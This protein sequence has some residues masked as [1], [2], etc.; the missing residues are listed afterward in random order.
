M[1]ATHFDFSTANA[2]ANT[3]TPGVAGHGL[4]NAGWHYGYYP[5]ADDP[6][7]V[8]T[9]SGMSP[10][11]EYWRGPRGDTT[12]VHDRFQ[13]HPADVLW[14]VV[15]RYTVGAA[16]GEPLPSG[17]VRIVGRF[18]D[19]N[20]GESDVF[21]AI[22]ADGPSGAGG[23]AFP[24]P[25]SAA[26]SPTPPSGIRQVRGTRGVGFDFTTT[27][28]SGA[29]ID[30]GVLA[31]GS[32][33]SD[34]TG[35]VAWLVTGDTAVPTDLVADDYSSLVF[36]VY[37]GSDTRGN[38]F[39]TATDGVFGG[40]DATS[41]DTTPG[42][43]Y[44]HAGLLYLE[45][46]GSGKVTRF[47][48]V[49]IDV[50]TGADFAELPHL[51]LLRHNSDPGSL[52][53]A[54]D[55]RYVQLPVTA[56]RTAANTA[57]QPYYTFDLTSLPESQRTGYGFAVFGRGGYSGGAIAVSEISADA[58]RVSDAGY[59][60][61]KPV[62]MEYDGH[63][64]GLSLNRGTW[65]QTEMEGVSYGGHLVSLNSAAE[66][67]WVFDALGR[68]PGTFIG[69]RQ[70][71]L[72]TNVEPNGGWTWMDGTV[73]SEINGSNVPGV[74][75]NWNDASVGG[76]EPNHADGAGED[77]GCFAPL[78]F[79]GR[80]TW[81]D[82]KNAGYP[83]TSNYRG[84]IEL[85]TPASPGSERNHQLTVSGQAN[86]FGAGQTDPTPTVSVGQGG[87]AAPYIPVFGGE[88]VRLTASGGTV[89]SGAPGAGA[90]VPDGE[91]HP[92]RRC[93]ITG[94]AGVSGY[95]N[96][97]NSAHLVGVFVSDTPLAQTPARLD[98]SADA[99]GEAFTSLSPGLGQVFFIG[100]GLT[101]GGKVQKFEA[102]AGATRL[103]IGFPDAFEGN[104]TYV[105]TGPPN[106]YGDNSGSWSIRLA[107]TPGPTP[108]ILNSRF[109]AS[110]GSFTISGGQPP[111]D[112]I[113]VSAGSLPPGITITSNTVQGRPTAGGTYPVTLRTEDAA[114]VEA[115]KTYPLNVAGAPSGM[116]A[117]WKADTDAQDSIGDN[118]GTSTG[119]NAMATGGG[120]VGSGSF[121]FT[122]TDVITVPDAEV[123]NLVGDFTM[124]MWL[125][126][127]VATGMEETILSKRNTDNSQVSYV[128]YLL[129]DGRLSFASRSLANDWVIT[130]TS[131]VLPADSDWRHL[132][133]TC[134]GT[135]L[136]FYVNGV[137]V[138]TT[139]HP[140]RSA[141]A[142]PL[143]IG[144][145]RVNGVATS[146]FDFSGRID[147]LSLYSRALNGSEISSIV[148]ADSMGKHPGTQ[149]SL[150]DGEL[151]FAGG[152]LLIEG[153]TGPYT[154]TIV[155]GSLPPGLAISSTGLV[156]GKAGNGAYAFTL[157][158]V[159]SLG[160]NSDRS[161]SGTIENP[162]P[163]VPGLLTWWPGENAVGE[164]I[165]GN[166]GSLKNGATYGAG[167]VGRS[168]SFDGVDDFALVPGS[169]ALNLAG[170]M[171]IE[172]WIKHSA[173]SAQEPTIIAKR[174][175]D[176]LNTAYVVFLLADGRLS[177]ASCLSGVWTTVSAPTPLALN[178]WNHVAVTLTGGQICFYV[179]GQLA[180]TLAFT[181][182][183]PTIPEPVTIG[184][185]LTSINTE[186]NP[187][188]EFPG[189][190][191]ELSLY[192]RALGDIEI[193]TIHLAGAGGK[194]RHDVARDYS[195]TTADGPVWSYRWLPS[196]ALNATYNP[197]DANANL[198]G[199]NATDGNG[200]D[201]WS[202]PSYISH[203]STDA[204]VG[205][206]S[207]G[208]QYDWNARQFGMGP[209]GSSEFAVV[210]WKAPQ[211]GLYAVSG[212]F[213]GCDT[214]PTTTDVH[215][216]HNATQLSPADKRAV[217]SYRGD[218]VSH[219][220]TI[221]VAANDTVDFVLG[222][223][224]NGSSYDSAGLAASIVLLTPVSAPEIA[225]EQPV[226]VGLADG[227]GAV[228]FGTS[229]LLTPLTR[230]F[231]IT[232]T[233]TAQLTLT[234][235][236]PSGDFI[237]GVIGDTTLDP[238]QSTTFTVTF[239][240]SAAGVRTGALHITSNDAD[241]SPF[242]I[243]LTGSGF[244]AVGNAIFAWGQGESSVIGDGTTIDRFTAVPTIMTGALANITVTSVVAGD[245]HNFAITSDGDLFSWGD[246]GYGQLGDGSTTT[247]SAPVAVDMS[248]ITGDVIACA[249]RGTLSVALTNEGK[250]YTWGDN[251]KGQLGL[252]TT[253]SRSTPQLVQGLLV[254]KNVVAI[255]AGLNF[256][257]VLTSTGEVFGWGANGYGMLRDGSTTDRLSPVALVKTG[258]LLQNK[259]IST[260]LCSYYR[261]LALDSDG[262]LYSWGFNGNGQLGDGSTTDRLLPVAVNGELAGKTVTA[263]SGN[264]AT[265]H[266]ALTS[267]GLLYGWG[268][269]FSGQIGDGST[270]ER[271]APVAVDMSGALLG[272][273]IVSIHTDGFSMVRTADN[274]L[275]T[276]GDNARGQLGV[277]PS[278]LGSLTPV[279][280][281][282]TGV[283]AG[284]TLV[285]SS[286]GGASHALVIGYAPPAPEITVK[287]SDN[288]ELTDGAS[289]LD[290]GTALPPGSTNLTVTIKN[291][292]NAV[293][294]G[295]N[296]TRSG[297]HQ[298]E[299]VMG[300]LGSTTLAPGVT[301]TFTVTF[302]PAASGAR[303]AVLHIASNDANENPFDIALIGTGGIPITD[304]RQTHFSTTANTGD[305]ADDADFDRDGVS[306]LLE[307]A[308]NGT[309]GSSDNEPGELAPLDNSGF[310][311]F[312][313]TRNKQA[314]AEITFQVEWTDD[315]ATP[316]S[317]AGVTE[318]ITSDNG[319]V[320]TVTATLP[321]VASGHRFVHLRVSR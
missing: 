212:T 271:R 5:E 58:V 230:T 200:L 224:G 193:S 251:F 16:N 278:L 98:F 130:P 144:G 184:A 299:F 178:V 290:L 166:H 117:W 222:A 161:F 269:N 318:T 185:S 143:T 75:R 11:P 138:Y 83:E 67:N 321:A 275:F 127:E 69:L 88:T 198:L 62:W 157:H 219:T 42:N 123:L 259:T 234:P 24:L 104:N 175:A 199:P 31:Q 202:G 155:S 49:R 220:Q 90:V 225:V 71:P 181:A 297:T 101:P 196:T 23:R 93:D 76:S 221:T 217:N 103:Y 68:G 237:P 142:G 28:A 169:T 108:Q 287:R 78:Y 132:A 126:R 79:S 109:P 1:A 253:P 153:G 192:N 118:D 240:P 215:I 150:T 273:Q 112:D 168:F 167:K 286:I 106:G 304:W 77:Y 35:L 37:S 276:W 160:A 246:N 243:A 174:S 209:G 245:S 86:I 314:M 44:T 154:V 3:W 295:L 80:S 158:V 6:N 298:T 94:V 114:N 255:S 26:D 296:I 195:T 263:I 254:G 120:V 63:R 147:E 152:Q 208:Y 141:T 203:N 213:F 128:L 43:A 279:A 55:E 85:A 41:F 70:N 288:S 315:F 165:G 188:G 218:G 201:S 46:S 319:L 100:D 61:A 40:T 247:R 54:Q 13:M 92:D 33:N 285:A 265:S 57:G 252:G 183:R 139:T 15:R 10:L 51:F 110:G 12:P 186:A 277:G 4:G 194:A 47:N 45:N 241:E 191:D 311:T 8:F 30:F 227:V 293:L 48:S 9:T 97:N 95:L 308:T 111:Y 307:F 65:E 135:T 280:V 164:I 261:T 171:T 105:Y 291:D 60:A 223:G 19:L 266:L 131:Y 205:I 262:K 231:T 72:Q 82:L 20:V 257:M 313:Y 207:G 129:T 309:P 172:G 136:R 238:A 214:R 204:F 149:P 312:T 159:D 134:S 176:N 256:V 17:D 270:T 89:N 32:Y 133:V 303:E 320:Q 84:I 87:V 151:P 317:S 267:D 182:T 116:V 170:D 306:N 156:T 146:D 34:S 39:T 289:T 250:V 7:G 305:A 264:R 300:P 274:K 102:P 148:N 96:R 232:N 53:P 18:Y 99:T 316:W 73:M 179:N 235:P 211:A 173:N 119:P 145:A 228:N 113:T 91:R 14:P 50:T 281:D 301:T 36:P 74:Y 310:I 197:T 239:T 244:N 284:K 189:S 122:G 242:D 236:V 187:I 125:K 282:M 22:D 27:V 66:N 302:T 56:V 25:A 229:E 233:G 283:L 52:N 124:E 81:G 137:L 292:G 272:K 268:S 21:I 226:G 162:I 216:F 206:S 107:V 64:Y 140:A 249:A 260:I 294:S 180:N 59:L 190:I 177:F 163:V 115:I 248:N 121:A 29:N 38:A 210:R 2:S 258:T